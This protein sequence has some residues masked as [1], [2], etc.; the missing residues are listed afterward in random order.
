MCWVQILNSSDKSGWDSSYGSFRVNPVQETVVF[1]NEWFFAVIFKNG[2]LD[3]Q[4]LIANSL[5]FI[6]E[7]SKLSNWATVQNSN[8]FLSCYCTVWEQK[9]VSQRKRC[10]SSP[11][12]LELVRIKDLV[13][14]GHFVLCQELGFMKTFSPDTRNWLKSRRSFM[15]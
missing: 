3:F 6:S 15:G 1:R 4:N 10:K 14:Q 8:F 7:P 5:H 11:N 12:I 9:G 13:A 2:P